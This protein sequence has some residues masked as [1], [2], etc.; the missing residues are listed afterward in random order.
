MLTDVI[1][2]VAH[3]VDTS[4]NG[5]VFLPSHVL[6]NIHHFMM[7]RGIIGIPAV[8]ARQVCGFTCTNFRRIDEKLYRHHSSSR[9]IRFNGLN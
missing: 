7:A 4:P 2:S 9:S 6:G 8:E 3:Q 1:R 5:G